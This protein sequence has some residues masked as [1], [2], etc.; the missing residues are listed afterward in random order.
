[1]LSSTAKFEAPAQPLCRRR[2]VFD[3]LSRQNEP[4]LAIDEIQ[5]QAAESRRRPALH[6]VAPRLVR[7]QRA[8]FAQPVCPLAPL[9]FV[10]S[11]L[12]QATVVPVSSHQGAHPCPRAISVP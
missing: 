9:D 6:R 12:R 7:A 11:F 10:V 8:P 2:A 3:E 1:M 5:G 4:V